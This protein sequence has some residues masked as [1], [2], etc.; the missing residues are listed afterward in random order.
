MNLTRELAAVHT[1]FGSTRD[2]LYGAVARCDFQSAAELCAELRSI[3]ARYTTI[4]AEAAAEAKAGFHTCQR[5]YQ[6]R[7]AV[8]ASG[9][10]DKLNE[11]DTRAAIA[12]MEAK[13]EG[14]GDE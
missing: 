10:A 8:A 4:R 9:D 1:Q 7:R 6:H 11:L 14:S 3:F 5:W 13:D 12:A 2:T